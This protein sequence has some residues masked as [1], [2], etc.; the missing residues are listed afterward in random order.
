MPRHKR[1]IGQGQKERRQAF[2]ALT[3]NGYGQF[4]YLIQALAPALGPDGLE[5]LKQRMIALSS[6]PVR[7]PA[8]KERQVIGWS[9]RGAIY[10]DEIAES[11]RVSTVR[12]A[13]QE[14]ADAQGDVDAFI[15]QYEASVRKVPKIAAKIAGRLLTAGRADEAWQILEATEHRRAGW[16][17]FEWRTPGSMSW[18]R[19]TAVMKH[20]QRA[21]PASNE[22]SPRRIY[23]RI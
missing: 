12:L 14:I 6:Q 9:S 19:G 11:S 15:A 10:A 5:H 8:A 1:G 4:D 2:D 17:D 18:R 13:L 7:K 3:R 22:P 16:R 23:A 20:R 21:G